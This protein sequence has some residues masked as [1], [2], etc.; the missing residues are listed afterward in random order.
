MSRGERRRERLSNAIIVEEG[1][2]GSTRSQ[3]TPRP[4]HPSGSMPKQ[5]SKV[6]LQLSLLHRLRKR[7]PESRELEGDRYCTTLFRF[8]SFRLRLFQFP[9]VSFRGTFNQI[10]SKP[11]TNNPKIKKPK[12]QHICRR[13]VAITSQ[14]LE[15]LPPVP[16]IQR[17]HIL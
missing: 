16:I 9:F 6:V 4:G 15:L 7:R 2:Q 3:V 14:L 11:K 12:S 8:V 17:I 1:E 5:N 13:H 10:K